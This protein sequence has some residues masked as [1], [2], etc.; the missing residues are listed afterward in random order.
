MIK[1][2]AVLILCGFAFAQP[3]VAPVREYLRYTRDVTISQP[4]KQNYLV[5]DA[6]IWARVRPDLSDLRLYDGAVQVPYALSEEQA[7]SSTV[8]R[9]ARILNLGVRDG[10]TEFDLDIGGEAEYNQVHLRLKATNFV[11]SATADGRDALTG[12]AGRKLSTST[13]YDFSREG[14]GNNFALRVP[15]ATFRYLHVSITP[16]ISPREITGASTSAQHEAQARWISAG[17]CHSS[18]QVSRT[19]RIACDL[20]PGVP[21]E[22]IL[23]T[24]PADIV[25]FRRTV[26]LSDVQGAPLC[27]GNVSRIRM[28]SSGREVVTEDLALNFRSSRERQILIDIDNGDNTPLTVE[29][30]EP[31]S[32]ERRIY[33]DPAGKTAVKLYYGDEKLSAPVFDYAR[34]FHKEADAIPA[35]MGVESQNPD[36]TGRPDERPW[37]ERHKWVLWGAMLLA[38]VV[39]ALLALKG[40]ASD[41]PA[42]K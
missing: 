17:R 30:A 16:A 1:R 10:R 20:D 34:F 28:K 8:E 24:V 25:N 11:V 23:F 37:S 5:V 39:L 22:R 32:L 40:L 38:V 35:V 9:E 36:Y 7:S 14:L 21:V 13:L 2:C 41:T 33:F 42:P 12:S 27:S 19:T 29:K 6:A 4:G 18:E 3:V 31:Q 26:T 15:L